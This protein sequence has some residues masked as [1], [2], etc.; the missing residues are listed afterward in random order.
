MLYNCVVFHEKEDLDFLGTLMSLRKKTSRASCVLI[1]T[2]T[3]VGH[4]QSGA[5]RGG[6]VE[7][8]GGRSQ[9]IH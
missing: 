3:K 5:D 1:V 4:A 9:A 7:G 6:G 2:L 8:S